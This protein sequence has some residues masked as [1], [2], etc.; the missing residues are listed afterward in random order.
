MSLLHWVFPWNLE[1]LFQKAMDTS[2]VVSKLEAFLWKGRALVEEGEEEE[3]QGE[4]GGS[5]RGGGAAATG[6]ICWPEKEL[7]GEGGFGKAGGPTK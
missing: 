1:T 2:G 3:G 6:A 5:R 4:G 7:Q